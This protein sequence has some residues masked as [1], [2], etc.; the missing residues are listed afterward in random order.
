MNPC[1]S[2]TLVVAALLAAF[3]QA[4]AHDN[5]KPSFVKGQILCANYDGAAN[6]LL[7][8]GL[9]A[10]GIQSAVAPGFTNPL[11]PTA[12]ELRKRAIHTNYRAV[13]D[14]TTNGGFGVLYGPNID[15]NGNPGQG[16]IAGEECLAFADNGSGKKNVTMMVQIPAGFD[17]ANA[18]IV[19]G[20]SSGSRGVYGAIG[21][22]G[23]WG[24]KRGCA[25][26]Y[27]DKGSG[28]G[29]HDLQNDTVNLIDGLRAAAGVA[30]KDSNFT[31]KVDPAKLASFN[32]ATPNR[33]AFKHAHLQQNPEEDWG[34]D[35][36]N[37]IEFAFYLL[38]ERFGEKNAR[39]DVIRR[40]VRK[41]NTIVIASSISNGGGA[42]VRAAEADWKGLIDGVAVTEPNVQPPQH[43]QVHVLRGGVPVP[44]HGK[45]IYD[46]FTLANLF[47]PCASRAA[48][49]AASPLLTFVNATIAANR[50]AALKAKGLLNGTTLAEQA[51]E[52]LAFLH[53]SGWEADSD[54]LHASHY[55]FATPPVAVTYANTYG[56]FSVLDNLCGFSFGATDPLATSPTF[57]LPIP[58]PAAN[59]ARI[60]GTGNGIP[61]TDGINI[62]NNNS[63]GG[64][65]LDGVSISANGVPDFNADGALCLRNLLTAKPGDEGFKDSVRVRL[66]VAKVRA[67]GHLRGKPAI[68]VHGRA[69]TLVPV[70]HS[71][72]PYFALNKLVEGDHSGLRYYEVAN[73]QHFDAFLGLA[74]YDTRFIPLHYYFTQAMNLM[75]DHLKNGT[76]L[77]PSQVVRTTPRG[78]SAGAA[79]AITPGNLPPISATPAAGDTIDFGNGAIDVPN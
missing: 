5:D 67:H 20:P 16:P 14:V 56:R 30:G 39:G 34:E 3:G 31:A 62:I 22:A 19:A 45:G 36:L 63:L 42:S 1:L 27:T 40:T 23:E 69:D 57:T 21:T 79:P 32:A 72:R 71:S 17:P 50:C 76:P 77:P 55:A 4:V 24:L 12:A 38:N 66:G 26:A 47:Q 49:L 52:A 25:V 33:F 37:S 48:S 65:R 6:D 15:K 46:Y 70:N 10:A 64:P 8:G 51:D 2:H 61:P 11:N 53:A 44:S 13:M 35:V 68:I 18:C 78:G 59:V 54:L 73:G 9:G 58:A 43:P 75:Y 74:G 28:N 60:F 29:A 41:H 7:T